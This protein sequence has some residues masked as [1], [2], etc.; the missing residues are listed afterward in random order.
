[1]KCSVFIEDMRLHAYHGVM[2]QE[3]VV[4]NDYAVTLRVDYPAEDAISNDNLAG[5]ISYADLAAIIKHEMSIAS[6]LVEHVAG[7]I[8]EHIKRDYPL[9]GVIYIKVKKLAPPMQA[10]CNGAG[11]ELLYE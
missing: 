5:T 3:R 7:R 1:M 8:A 4:G 2:E 11:V 6:A 9:A 10:D